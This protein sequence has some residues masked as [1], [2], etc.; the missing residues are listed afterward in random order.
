MLLSCVALSNKNTDARTCKHLQAYLGLE[1]EQ[2][3]CHDSFAEAAAGV[4]S[5]NV[6]KESSSRRSGSDNCRCGARWESRDAWRLLA[7]KGTKRK[8]HGWWVSE[9]T[10]FGPTGTHSSLISHGNIF[11]APESPRRR[12]RSTSR[13]MANSLRRKIP[14][15]RWYC[16]SSAAH[17]EAT[18][19]YEIFDIPSSGSK[20]FEERTGSEFISRKEGLSSMCI[21]EQA[22]VTGDAH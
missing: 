20:P 7:N 10:A 19:T 13:W 16:Q 21:V 1:F 8:L 18:L 15:D 14:I 6:A 5:P 3:R 9:R 2:T 11:T 17:P 12:R 22:I 4:G